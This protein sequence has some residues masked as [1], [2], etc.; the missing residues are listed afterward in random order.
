MVELYIWQISL[1]AIVA[2][3]GSIFVR[4]LKRIEGEPLDQQIVFNPFKESLK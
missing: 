3:I 1:G 4:K 2:T